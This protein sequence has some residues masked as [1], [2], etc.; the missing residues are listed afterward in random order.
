MEGVLALAAGQV[1]DRDA[2]VAQVLVA[3]HQLVRDALGVP[4]LVVEPALVRDAQVARVLAREAQKAQV[5][6]HAAMTALALVVQDARILAK[7]LRNI[8]AVL[9]RKLAYN[10][11]RIHAQNPVLE[12]AL[13]HA[14]W[15]VTKLVQE[16]VMDNVHIIAKAVL[17]LHAVHAIKAVAPFAMAVAL[18]FAYL[19][20]VACAYP[21]ATEHVQD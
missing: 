20:A 5:V 8:L 21:L 19:L 10:H 17:P 6:P 7:T 16:C 4:I 13:T 18:V 14:T 9:A 15:H 11:V 3:A 1:R 2:Q 12:L